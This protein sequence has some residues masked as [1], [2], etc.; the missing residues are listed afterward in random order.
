MMGEVQETFAEGAFH[1]QTL[2]AAK[3]FCV[4]LWI[5]LT[6]FGQCYLRHKEQVQVLSLLTLKVQD[7]PKTF[8]YFVLLFVS[9]ITLCFIFSIQIVY[10][11]TSDR[12]VFTKIFFGFSLN[13]NSVGSVIFFLIFLF[14]ILLKFCWCV[15]RLWLVCARCETWRGFGNAKTQQSNT[16]ILGGEKKNSQ[17]PHRCSSLRRSSSLPRSL[18]LN[19]FVFGWISLALFW[20]GRAKQQTLSSLIIADPWHASRVGQLYLLS[21]EQFFNLNV[22]CSEMMNL[23]NGTRVCWKLLSLLTQMQCTGSMAGCKF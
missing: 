12:D 22:D 4:P 11:R 15:L 8:R 7:L 18:F 21:R 23:I 16:G 3:W 17:M 13:Y 2:S 14:L 9:N 1:L 6:D 10:V 20:F 5:N 19:W